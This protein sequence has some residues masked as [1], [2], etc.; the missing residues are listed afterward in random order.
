MFDEMW[1]EEFMFTSE[2]DAE[3]GDFAD[4]DADQVEDDDDTKP[5]KSVD[6]EDEEL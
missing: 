2:P 6:E 1:K 5:E 3:E 4:P